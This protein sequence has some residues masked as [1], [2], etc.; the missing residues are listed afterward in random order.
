MALIAATSIFILATL[1]QTVSAAPASH[2]HMHKHV[3]LLRRQYHQHPDE[4]IRM[5]QGP[6]HNDPE[7]IDSLVDP[8]PDATGHPE[9]VVDP[10]LGDPLVTRYLDDTAL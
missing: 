2:H 8:R 9:M 4:V 5:R 6:I 3:A 1:L 10:V 7:M